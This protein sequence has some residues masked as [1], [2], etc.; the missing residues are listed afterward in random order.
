M[1]QR[2]SAACSGKTSIFLFKNLQKE[3]PIVPRV[4]ILTIYLG[5]GGV[6][7]RASTI[8]LAEKINITLQSSFLKLWGPLLPRVVPR[9]Q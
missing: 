9:Q 5:L 2:Y 3:F 7:L 6:Q 1:N 4:T 8:T